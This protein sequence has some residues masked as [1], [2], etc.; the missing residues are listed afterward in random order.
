[1]TSPGVSRS[2]GAWLARARRSGRLYERSGM[3][4][5]GHKEWE[6]ARRFLA[7]A[8]HRDG[9]ILDIGCG[10]G[11][12]VRSLQEWSGQSLEPY[13]VDADDEVVERCRRLFRG[14][15]RRFHC[16]SLEDLPRKLRHAT[17]FPDRFDFVF[18]G[19]WDNWGF[20]RPEQLAALRLLR[21]LAGPQGRVVLAFY[22][23]H[24]F[25]PRIDPSCV[26]IGRALE[27]GFEFEGAALNT[28]GGIGAAVWGPGVRGG[29]KRLATLRGR[30]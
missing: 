2:Y 7:A 9:S 30:G 28:R 27:A 16:S 6:D 25:D 20:D 5:G 14:G 18:W 17:A 3:I 19:V 13:G 4:S 26:R 22:D 8:I 23:V 21:R 15:A 12:L 11:L 24:S 29:L 1:M 10:N